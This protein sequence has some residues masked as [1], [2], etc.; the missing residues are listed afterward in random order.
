MPEG[1]HGTHSLDQIS[2]VEPSPTISKQYLDINY[3]V[4]RIPFKTKEL[5]EFLETSQD[6][7]VRQYFTRKV[8]A[9]IAP[10]PEINFYIS[11]ET[12]VK[13]KS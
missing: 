5:D 12:R 7:S 13:L 4:S 11:F 1:I 2:K 6:L 10:L 8:E 9:Q 3:L